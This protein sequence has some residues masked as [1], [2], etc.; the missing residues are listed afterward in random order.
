MSSK[1]KTRFTVTAGGRTREFLAI[2]E[3][4][5][6]DLLFLFRNEKSWGGDTI[7]QRRASLHPCDRSK[8]GAVLFKET[9]TTARGVAD[10]ASL[11]E[12]F[13]AHS[14]SLMVARRTARIDTDTYDVVPRSK[15]SI[16][17]YGEMHF[18]DSLLYFVVASGVH[19]DATAIS[20]SM[21]LTWQSVKFKRFAVHIGACGFRLLGAALRFSTISRKTSSPVRW[22]GS[23]VEADAQTP[24]TPLSA[25]G[26]RDEIEILAQLICDSTSEQFAARN[27][28]RGVPLP[29][30]SK[31]ALVRLGLAVPSQ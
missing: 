7:V 31:F 27:A 6:G 11:V 22:N 15:D 18:S 20:S 24:F 23:S 3:R 9:V 17:S 12:R 4:A 13:D 8:V 30:H 5:P 16:V 1:P 28:G 2:R 29:D 21:P 26:L 25:G 19:Y 14:V 10:M